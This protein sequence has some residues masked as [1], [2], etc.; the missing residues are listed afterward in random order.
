MTHQRHH[1]DCRDDIAQ[2]P[3]TIF[4]IEIVGFLVS[5]ADGVVVVVPRDVDLLF[6]F[7]ELVRANLFESRFDPF[8]QQVLRVRPVEQVYVHDEGRIV[9]PPHS[10]GFRFGGERHGTAYHIVVESFEVYEYRQT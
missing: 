7:L 10:E 5:V 4:R 3:N 9:H 6:D 1:V 8:N 2:I